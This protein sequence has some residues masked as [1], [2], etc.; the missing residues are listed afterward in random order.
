MKALVDIPDTYRARRRTSKGTFFSRGYFSYFSLIFL[1]LSPWR[2][3]FPSGERTRSR[4]RAG[5]ALFISL[6]LPPSLSWQ[7]GMNSVGRAQDGAGQ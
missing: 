3:P 5:R 7:R 6:A 2:T 4:L 1:V